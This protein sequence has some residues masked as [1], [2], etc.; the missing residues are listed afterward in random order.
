MILLETILS[1]IVVL[2]IAKIINKPFL[3]DRQISLKEKNITISASSLLSIGIILALRY[4]FG[5]LGFLVDSFQVFGSGVP[6]S[7]KQIG[8]LFFAIM[9]T[10]FFPIYKFFLEKFHKTRSLN[11]RDTRNKDFNKRSV[12]IIGISWIVALVFL[13]IDFL[14]RPFNSK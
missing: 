1:M 6:D 2:F 11:E 8:F 10:L 9:I 4:I 14:D 12:L 5:Y 3:K 13:S 7:Y